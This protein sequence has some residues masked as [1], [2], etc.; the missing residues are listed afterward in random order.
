[1]TSKLKRKLGE[2]G[3]DLT[4]RKA[5]ENFCLIGTPLPPL[6]KSKDTGEF[7]PLW[8]Q[9]VRDEKGRR[10]LHGAFTGGF[11]AGYF[12]T[13]GSKEG[14]APSTFVSSRADR[15]KQK[16]ARP[17]DFMDEED[18][19]ELQESRKLVTTNEQMDLTAEGQTSSGNAVPDNDP[20]AATL[21]SAF[22]PLSNDSAGARILKKMGWRSGQGIGPRVSLKERK[23]QDD[24]AFDPYTGFKYAGQALSV[25]EDDEE[26]SKHTYPRRDIPVLHVARKDNRHGLGYTTGMKL[27]DSLGRTGET[28]SGPSISAGFGLGALND[29]DEDDIDIYDAGT[30]SRGARVAFD[31]LDYDREETMVIGSKSERGPQ[32]KFQ[33]SKTQQFFP[34]GTPVVQGFTASPD[35]VTEDTWHPGP[36]VPSGWKP[37]PRRVWDSNPNKENTK[38]PRTTGTVKAGRVELSAQ[39]RATILGEEP[40]A[41]GPRSV[42][43]FI[44]AK[45]KERIKR[46]AAGASDVPLQ[47]QPPAGPIPPASVS[48]IE[49]SVAQAALLGFQPFTANPA[50]QARYTA[51]LDSQ[52]T[53]E[54]APPLRQLPNQDEEGFRQE[55][56]EYTKSAQLFKPMSGAMAGRFT[57]AS[58]VEMGPKIHEGLHQPTEEELK[59]NEEEKLREEEADISPKAH[60]AKI[61]MYGPLTR[62][63]STWVPVSLLCK[64]FGVK[65]PEVEV[66]DVVVDE[67][68]AKST[69][70]QEAFASFAS[71]SAQGRGGSGAGPSGSASDLP[72]RLENIGLGEDE[73]QGADILTYERP[74]MDIFKAIFASDDEDSDGE[75]G[76]EG[77]EEEVELP[78]KEKVEVAQDTGPVDL[79]TFKPTFIPRE[80]KGKAKNDIKGTDKKSK[81]KKD[82]K[83]KK[84]KGGMLS[85]DVG[86]EE[87][88]PDLG[89]PIKDR[90][91][92]KKKRKE[93]EKAVGDNDAGMYVDGPTLT[94]APPPTAQVSDSAPAIDS[95]NQ[96][97]AVPKGRKRAIDF[98]DG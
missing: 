43:D 72:R 84:R 14:W 80:G 55:L 53:P 48:K 79:A 56:N 51:Y 86:D 41:T 36:D 22:Q 82:K 89:N 60:A 67:P 63:V 59:Q 64:R 77:K 20:I 68:S 61:G 24:E 49:P 78:S 11:S 25:D 44:S 28:K 75:D 33:A 42:F 74:S 29:A 4:S 88:E 90:E 47:E 5:T 65:Q 12:N 32:P 83:D 30:T 70:E 92:P 52:A 21:K 37:D 2:I 93:K 35:P 96:R 46:I 3:V 85:F 97:S 66:E 62:E 9:E 69:F 10:R 26:A 45:D 76:G 6:E 94:N 50:K 13:V 7:V 38:Q 15:A 57:S 71:T 58:N 91:R 17:E 98:L 40:L 8:K 19:Q 54:S 16:A 18:L 34:D 95:G 81:E 27:N 1:M 23:R 31:H 73:T 87:G 39:A